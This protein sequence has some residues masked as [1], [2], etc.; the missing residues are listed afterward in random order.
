MTVGPAA[1]ARVLT[2]TANTLARNNNLDPDQ[3]LRTVL[4]GS[5]NADAPGTN[6][7]Q[8]EL[9]NTADTAITVYVTD[10]GNP[11]PALADIRREQAIEAASAAAARIRAAR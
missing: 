4:W 11:L 1:I 9:Y 8:A 5:P 6:E 7:V 3:A 2:A 10:Q